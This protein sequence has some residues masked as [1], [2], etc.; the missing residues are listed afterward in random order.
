MQICIV[1]IMI[2]CNVHLLSLVDSRKIRKEK[3]IMIY[4]VSCLPLSCG[5]I[6]DADFG[7]ELCL[8]WNSCSFPWNRE[9]RTASTEMQNTHNSFCPE[10]IFF[11]WGIPCQDVFV[12]ERE[13][14]EDDDVVFRVYSEHEDA[15][16][17]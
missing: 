13:S 16:S 3:K 1:R 11:F 10:F 2:M 4:L 6:F 5:I 9:T 17:L 15:Y 8:L 7:C 14:E 12:A